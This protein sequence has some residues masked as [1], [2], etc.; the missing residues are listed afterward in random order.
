[1]APAASRE[2]SR[3]QAILKLQPCNSFD[4]RVRY[5]PQSR[6]TLNEDGSNFFVETKAS[7][8]YDDTIGEKTFL[9][10]KLIVKFLFWHSTCL[11]VI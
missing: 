3:P 4:H 1:M 5:E 6:L 7:K 11:F 8:R 2:N 10:T 9:K